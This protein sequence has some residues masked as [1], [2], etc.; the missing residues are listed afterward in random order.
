MAEDMFS[1]QEGFLK[2]FTSSTTKM[3]ASVASFIAGVDSFNTGNT[4]LVSILEKWGKT[5]TLSSVVITMEKM[6]SK[7]NDARLELARSFGVTGAKKKEFLGIIQSETKNLRQYGITLSDSVEVMSSLSDK[8][9]SLTFIKDK[10]GLIETTSLIAKSFNASNEAAADI[11]GSMSMFND[12]G[13]QG[14]KS[15]FESMAGYADM[16]NVSTSAVFENMRSASNMMYLFN[17]KATDG[18]KSFNELSV[19]ATAL[20]MNLGSAITSLKELRNAGQAVRTSAELSQMGIQMSANRLMGM[21]FGQDIVG[22]TTAMLSQMEGK[23]AYVQERMAEKIG[24]AVGMSTEETMASFERSRK[25]GFQKLLSGDS[26]ALKNLESMRE[27]QLGFTDRLDNLLSHVM[28]GIIDPMAKVLF[29]V[30]EGIFKHT[31]LL[32]G[33]L[34]A[35]LGIFAIQ[36]ASQLGGFALGTGGGGLFEKIKALG[37]RNVKGGGVF[38]AAEQAAFGGGGKSTGKGKF[39]G[40]SG[41]GMLQGA[42]G[43]LA[44]AAAMWVMSKALQ[45]FKDIGWDELGKAGAALGGFALIAGIMGLGPIPDAIIVGGLALGIASIGFAAFGAAMKVFS[46]GIEPLLGHGDDLVKIGLGLGA[47]FASMLLFPIAGIGGIIGGLFGTSFIKPIEQLAEF[48]SKPQ[49]I[50]PIERLGKALINVGDGLKSISDSNSLTSLQSSIS[51]A[52]GGMT[53]IPEIRVRVD[54]D[55]KHVADALGK[56]IKGDR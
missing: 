9:G 54:I 46:W 6:I 37:S 10:K 28:G 38:S 56:H 31:K 45:N 8:F 29:P 23:S 27:E 41:K 30:L 13:E 18:S 3:A 52:G 20:G 22:G 21:G 2:G 51:L 40:F 26:A 11:A 15:V 34:Y 39:G 35:S 5:F 43:L 17:L 55:G 42:T 1:N 49:N 7:Y 47:I 50:E 16:T 12:L 19:G 36:K 32:Q 24:A 25:I 48:A 44:M 33:I 14:I 4:E 53:T